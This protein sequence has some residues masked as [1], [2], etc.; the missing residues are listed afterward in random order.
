MPKQALFAGLVIDETG[1]PAETTYVGDEPCYVTHRESE[2]DRGI[3]GR[4]TG[5]RRWR[6][7]GG[8]LSGCRCRCHGCHRF[9]DA[10]GRR[11]RAGGARAGE[12]ERYRGYLPRASSGA[13]S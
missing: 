4:G 10:E 8:G 5:R 6:G 1:V 3:V 11:A 7:C 12:D 9:L 2:I 13:I